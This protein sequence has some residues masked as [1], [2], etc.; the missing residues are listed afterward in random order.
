MSSER[1]QTATRARAADADPDALLTA[2]GSKGRGRGARPAA[3]NPV[4]AN[5]PGGLAADDTPSAAGVAHEHARPVPI[6]MRGGDQGTS[7]AVVP[8][9]IDDLPQ[10]VPVSRAELAVLEAYLGSAIDALLREFKM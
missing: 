3:K 8:E 6:R 7:E 10:P 9:V 1:H 5:R 4:G 2:N